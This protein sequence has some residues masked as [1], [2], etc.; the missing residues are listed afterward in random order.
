[1]INKSQQDRGRRKVCYEEEKS[2]ASLF[3]CVIYTRVWKVW[4]PCQKKSQK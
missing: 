2:C 1:M 3:C 4:N